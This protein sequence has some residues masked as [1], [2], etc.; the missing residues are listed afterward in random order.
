M[1]FADAPV[2]VPLTPAALGVLAGVGV[3]A[4]GVEGVVVVVPLFVA[5]FVALGVALGVAAVVVVVVGV[6]AAGVLAV[7]PVVVVDVPPPKAVVPSARP[8]AEPN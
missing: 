1:V 5:F 2:N 6:V 4:A 8:L 7:P 3:V